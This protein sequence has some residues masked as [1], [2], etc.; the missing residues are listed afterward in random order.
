VA[1]SRSKRVVVV[2]VARKL[3]VSLCNAAI[4]GSVPQEAGLGG[5]R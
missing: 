3:L 4:T 5:T 2:G 1:D